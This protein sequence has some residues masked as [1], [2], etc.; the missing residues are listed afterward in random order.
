MKKKIFIIIFYLSVILYAN[1]QIKR[2][3]VIYKKNYTSQL[4]SNNEEKNI[5][6]SMLKKMG[7]YEE[8]VIEASKDISFELIFNEGESTFEIK[9]LLETEG[10]KFYKAAIGPEAA[11]SFYCD[12]N[13]TLW[14][15][16]AFGEDFIVRKKQ[17]EWILKQETKKIGKYLCKKAV[18]IEVLELENKIKKNIVTAWYCPEINIPFGPIGY[19]KLPGLIIELYIGNSRFYVERISLNPNK[20]LKV[21]K[22]IK[23]KIVTQNEFYNI[24]RGLMMDFKKNRMN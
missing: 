6:S 14:K 5:E 16:N 22:P 23:G 12:L 13:E 10:K 19:N 4:F 11:G 7:D 8:K 15:V 3:T 2:G 18:L 1:G 24:A 21:K 20:E 17:P 9:D